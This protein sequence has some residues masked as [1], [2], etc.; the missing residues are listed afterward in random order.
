MRGDV[1][2]DLNI[3]EV[4][5]NI[6]DLINERLVVGESVKGGNVGLELTGVLGVILASV[7]VAAVDL[8]FL[9][10]GSVVLMDCVWWPC[11]GV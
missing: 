1:V 2:V 4:V 10:G 7:V 8:K 5:L 9:V 3:C 6:R 11:V